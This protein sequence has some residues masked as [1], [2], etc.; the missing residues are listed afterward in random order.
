ML[1]APSAGRAAEGVL[2]DLLAQRPLHPL[3]VA[4]R[5][6]GDVTPRD[7]IE[8]MTRVRRILKLIG[9][10]FAFVLYVWFAAV[11]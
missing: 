7:T 11:R 4:A 8:P 9:A 6:V 1:R 10:A 2:E 5:H 3:D